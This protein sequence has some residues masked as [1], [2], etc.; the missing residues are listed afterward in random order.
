MV[1]ENT[2]AKTQQPT[3]GI[4]SEETTYERLLRK[5][6]E[7]HQKEQ[8]NSNVDEDPLRDE[9]ADNLNR[10]Y[11]GVEVMVNASDDDF[12]DSESGSEADSKDEHEPEFACL[13]SSTQEPQHSLGATPYPKMRQEKLEQ[14]RNYPDFKFLV[15]EV[16][17][18][19]SRR[20]SSAGNET[21][22]KSI[23]RVTELGDQMIK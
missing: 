11:D 4:S 12:T 7:K 6:T 21:G 22:G 13:G 19:M 20:N 18:D 17:T 14:W 5:V 3:A 10:S 15:S 1:K 23:S 9:S 8:E 2:Q 16:V